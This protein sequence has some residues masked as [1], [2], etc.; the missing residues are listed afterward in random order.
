LSEYLGRHEEAEEYFAEADKLDRMFRRG[1][2]PPEKRREQKAEDVLDELDGWKEEAWGL[3]EMV[4]DLTHE[5]EELNKVLFQERIELDELRAQQKCRDVGN[6][7]HQELIDVREEVK[8]LR[9]EKRHDAAA[10][11]S[12][13]KLPQIIKE[14]AELKSEIAVLIA[15][16]SKDRQ[17]LDASNQDMKRLM[18]TRTEDFKSKTMRTTAMKVMTHAIGRWLEGNCARVLHRW[19]HSMREH[20]RVFFRGRLLDQQFRFGRARFISAMSRVIRYEWEA[21]RELSRVGVNTWRR[22]NKLEAFQANFGS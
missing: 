2:I 17:N 16:L 10:A 9:Y 7:F 4:R 21:L 22:R 15:T 13:K 6:E 11:V 20:T 1:L 19:C 18:Q 3:G 12:H 5:T 8:Q 14:N